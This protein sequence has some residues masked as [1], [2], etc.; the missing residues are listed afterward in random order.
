VLKEN[1]MKGYRRIFI[2]C[3]LC[4]CLII[5]VLSADQESPYKE[6]PI[7]LAQLVVKV[8]LIGT[9]IGIP[10]I[11]VAPAGHNFGSVNEG[12][13]SSYQT[14]TVSNIGSTKL[15][16]GTVSI[17]GTDVSQFIKEKD[18]CSGQSL[19]VSS[20]CTIDMVF[21]PT[22]I[23]PKNAFML[24]PSNDPDTQALNVT[25]NG[26]GVGVPTIS[27]I[28]S[29]YDDYGTIFIGSSSSPQIFTVYNTG[30]GNLIIGTIL[31]TGTDASQ[32][33]T[34][35]DNCSGR[36]IAPSS[37]CSVNAVFSPT[38]TGVKIA[39]LAIP[40]NDQ[41]MPVFNVPLLG[42]GSGIPN[43]LVSPANY[44]FG[45]LFIGYS[46]GEATFTMSN[47]GTGDLVI[48]SA[49]ITGTNINDFIITEDKCFGK[50][51]SPSSV[52]SIKIYF[53]P[54]SIGSKNANLTVWSN[55]PDSRRLNTLLTG[56]GV[57]PTGI[58]VISPNG[59]EI[60]KAGTTQ[61]IRWSY[62]GNPGS[63]V[64]IELYKGGLFDRTIKSSTS[65]GTGGNGSYSWAIPATQS[66]GDVYT[67]VVTSTSNADYTAESDDY[68]IIVPATI[69]VTA[70]NG[71]ENWRAG[72]TQ[73]IRWSY[74]GNPGS[75]VKIELLKSGTVNKIIKS[76]TS[77]GGGSFNWTIPS[78]QANSADYKIRITSTSNSSIKDSSDNNLTISK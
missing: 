67:V 9:G 18:T 58:M 32:Y 78:N 20:S 45:D 34:Q 46:S 13:S 55:D 59:S 14:F 30:T 28:P 4:Y 44:N 72:T 47:T 42:T 63:Y 33:I 40:S 38:S 54:S 2:F 11:S 71:G 27:V 76:S 65:R 74:T 23:G 75:N 50:R 64:K 69:T 26:T 15:I 57:V 68:F 61:T 36:I 66:G 39:N 10:K 25:L 49:A 7:Q 77:I 5:S 3:L 22:S 19:A 6:P 41:D 31:F 35:S 52:C 17:A 73:T 37:N 62:E 43:I 29:S 8:P 56:R 70:P 53:I 21:S 12:S 1:T 16:V 48:S 51:L 60:W 24:I